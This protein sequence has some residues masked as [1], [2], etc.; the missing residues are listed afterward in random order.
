SASFNISFTVTQATVTDYVIPTGLTAIFE[1]TL[2][3]VTLPSGWAWDNPNA[4]VGAVGQ[5]MHSAT[6]TRSGGFLPVTRNV[7]I[8]V[9]QA[10]VTDYVIPTGLTAIFGQTLAQVTLTSG[11]AWD[12]PNASVGDVGQQT[13]S[14]TYTR[15]GG[16][17]PVTRNVEITVTQATVT[18]YI[19][20]TGLTA[21]FGQTLAQI[22]L[23]SGWAWDNPNA[24]VGAVGQ[25]T[26]SATYTRS[27]N[28][29][30]VTR[31]VTI[32]VTHATVTDYVIPTGLTAIF[33]QTLAQVTLPSNWAWDNPNASVGAVGQQMHS[34]TY[35]RSGGFLPVTRNVPVTVTQATVTDYIIPTGLTAE[36]GQTL[37]QVAL[38]ANWAWVTPNASVGA[39]GQQTHSATYTRSANFLPVTRNVTITVTSV[40]KM[41]S[42][43]WFHSLAVTTCGQLWA[44][45]S[46]EYGRTGLNTDTGLTLVPTRV[47]TASNW[48]SVSAGWWHSHA[49]TTC[50]QL[51][52]WGWNGAG[53]TGLGIGTT[54]ATT[55]P[56]RVGTASNWAQVSAGREHSLAVT[57]NG[58]LWAWGLND[59]GR[60]GLGINDWSTTLVPTRVGTASNWASVSAGDE[61]SLAVTTNGQLYAWG[62][63]THG[64]T[65]LGISG[66]GSSTNV[67]TRVGFASNWASVSAG[68]IHSHAVTT[69]G[70]LWAWGSNANGR[71]GLGI[72]TNTTT[73]TP[74]R[75][76]NASNWASVSAGAS[77][78]L[79][80]TTNGQ[81]WAW[82]R[83]EHGRTG[84]GIDNSWSNTLVPTRV[85]FASNWAS[86][87]AGWEHSHAITTTGQLWAWGWNSS[88]RTGLGTTTGNTIV[89][90]RVGGN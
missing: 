1:Q 16:F 61:H 24:S 15:S 53:A 69:C 42:A 48:A 27:A 5:Q 12:N 7:T 87:S 45:G 34:A 44:W 84:L 65:G 82:G 28:F 14:A 39:V 29:L 57:T 38:P 63:N 73:T 13:H 55:T 17:L 70:Q 71:T 21:I 66:V 36:F 68:Y 79:A 26:H 30:P 40:W 72:G 43:G 76:G 62:L 89:P 37:A 32:T 19:I 52:A 9:T 22:T 58:Q 10:T 81:L 4:L 20:P 75:V 77:H 25:Q 35:T 74:T 49:V 2:A 11:W 50:G 59:A 56:T 60:T 41:V 3:Q 80:V 54:T 51:W 83:N 23:T 46:N 31:N 86:V 33:E 88:G 47:G 85:G 78:S 8:T 18:D 6:Y 67:P 90:T 64:R